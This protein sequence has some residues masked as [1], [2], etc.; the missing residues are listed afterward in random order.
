[1]NKLPYKKPGQ[2]QDCKSCLRIL[3]PEEFYSDKRNKNGLRSICKRCTREYNLSRDRLKYYETYRNSVKGK[4]SLS[5]YR[6][7]ESYKER[8]RQK[9]REP[10]CKL[11]NKIRRQTDLQYKLK[12][13]LR[14]RVSSAI[15]E[16]K[17]GG[18]AVKDLGCSLSKLKLHL[19]KQ[20]SPGMSWNNRGSR[21]WHIDHITPLTM[22]D[23]AQK[24]QFL[25]ACH[26]SNLQPMWA[27][28]N[29]RKGNR[30]IE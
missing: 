4:E 8:D 5:K 30:M 16:G 1:M 21:G 12:I 15:R 13:L 27:T 2:A 29:I 9:H 20:F 22:F 3:Q 11:R 26:Y 25:V 6:G 17:K 7:T 23:L 24:D 14:K 28:D 18:S 10:L 19:E